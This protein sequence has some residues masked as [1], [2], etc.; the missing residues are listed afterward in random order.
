M[1]R[2]ASGAD[3][4]VAALAEGGV[5]TVFGLP[6]TQTVPLFES[7][8]RSRLRTVL[9]THELGAGFMA[10]GWAR[11]SGE[12]G[13]LATIPGPGFT[14]ALT[15]LAEARLDSV[16]LLHLCGAPPATPGRRFRQQELDQAAIAGPLVKAVLSANKVS[17]ISALV[18]L[19]LHHAV[20][21][22]PGPVLLQIPAE[23]LSR[24]GSDEAAAVPAEPVVADFAGLRRRVTAA[25]RPVLFL[26]QGAGASAALL[27]R[28]AEGLQVPVVTT[29][30]GRG[31]LPEDHPLAMGFDGLRSEPAVLNQL[32]AAA[33]LVL[34]LGAKLG[35]NGTCGYGLIIPPDRLVHVDTSPEVLGAN[36]PASL[37]L[38]ADV[39][40]AVE[41]LLAAPLRGGDWTAAELAQW[42][43]R[44]RAPGPRGPEPS[45]CGG[46]PE[47]F[48][49]ALRRALPRET[50]L[51]LD[52][53]LHQIL[54]RRYYDVLSPRG[55]LL[56]SDLQSMGFGIP[57]AIGARLAAPQRPVVVIV[58]DGGFAMSG[59]ELLTA[60]REGLDLV[61]I[62]LVDGQLGQIRMQQLAEYGATHAVQLENP[63][64]SLFAAAIGAG[65]R[66]AG[67]G[68]ELAVRAALD[69]GG[70]TII[71]VP[72]G[73]TPRLRRAATVAR[74]RETA[75]RVVGPAAI[76]WLKRLL[77][78]S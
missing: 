30:A 52:S 1:S 55:L 40:L 51:V 17:E 76:R 58:G 22:E 24:E 37:A 32:F 42:R 28:L 61:V 19:G 5:S 68:I 35:H 12:V 62:V 7:L 8:R 39:R 47:R 27:T 49:A 3:L 25:R 60:V 56:P 46:E 69:Q 44:L 73:D 15:G 59:L 65:Y 75:R 53:G 45:V 23:L 74:T 72:V 38:V 63:D 9:T 6:G 41:A 21:G 31:T 14:W 70:V 29:A 48:F 43:Q 2:P 33:D 36:Y 67:D 26:G 66:N 18:R 11:S 13:V 71:E 57:T 77:D 20:S 78:R 10:G 4:L 50:G 54:A 64:F 16:P 34:V